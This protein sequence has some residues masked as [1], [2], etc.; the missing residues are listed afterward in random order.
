[1]DTNE[2]FIEFPSYVWDKKMLSNMQ[3]K[4]IQPPFP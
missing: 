2:L 1:M 3:I 4:E